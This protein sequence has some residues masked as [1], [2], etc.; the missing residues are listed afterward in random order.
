MSCKKDYSEEIEKLKIRRQNL[1]EEIEHFKLFEKYY[2][3]AD[4]EDYKRYLSDL[5]NVELRLKILKLYKKNY[6]QQGV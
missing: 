4:Q 5:R 1:I 6:C 2:M 3:K